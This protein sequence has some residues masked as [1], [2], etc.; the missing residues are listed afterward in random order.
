MSSLEDDSINGSV[1]KM[2]VFKDHVKET[3]TPMTLKDRILY[4]AI[5][6]ERPTRD[7]IAVNV[8]ASGSAGTGVSGFIREKIF[9]EKLFDCGNCVYFEVDMTKVHLE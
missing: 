7:S 2:H 1:I 8:S 9:I 4:Y 3:S 5:H 6:A